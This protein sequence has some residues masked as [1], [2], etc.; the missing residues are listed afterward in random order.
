[1][2]EIKYSI[3]TGQWGDGKSI[4]LW[5]REG[6]V[7]TKIARFSGEEAVKLFAKEFDFP[8]HETVLDRIKS[9]EV[10]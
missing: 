7:S 2:R 1:M 9:T 10:Q 5:R 3:S 8:L 6:V 4:C